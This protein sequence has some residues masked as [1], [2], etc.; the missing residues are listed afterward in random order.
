MTL[1]VDQ[2][3]ALMRSAFYG[4]SAQEIATAEQIPLGTAKSRIRIG[5]TKVRDALIEEGV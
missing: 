3:R 5:L 2:R 4:Q 1:P